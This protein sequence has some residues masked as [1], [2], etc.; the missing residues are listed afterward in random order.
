M[1]DRSNASAFA[2]VKEVTSGTFVAPSNTADLLQIADIKVQIDGITVDINE[3]TGSI[4]KVGS[5]VLGKSLTV[6]GKLY[7][8]GPGTSTPPV[9]DAWIP[10]RILQAGGL[11]ETVTSTAIPAAPEAVS[12]GTTTGFTLG[13]G[14]TGTLDLYKAMMIKLATGLGGTGNKLYTMIRSYAASKAA[15]IAETASGAITGNYQ[16]PK[17]LS[18]RTSTSSTIPTL[19]TSNWMGNYR[20][21]GVGM[22]ISAL[23]FVMPT[24]G[25]NASEPPYFEF[26]LTGDVYQ[27]ADETCPIVTA[28]LAIPPYRDGKLWVGNTQMGGTSFDVD[29]NATVAYPPNPN[30]ASGNE[31]ALLTGTQRKVS[32]NLNQYSKAT[33]DFIALADAQSYNAVMALWGSATGNMFGFLV[34]DARFNYRSPD[35]SAEY[36]TSTG[37]MFVDD[38][39][40]T[41]SLCIPFF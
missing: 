15:T 37:E 27:D 8:R 31:T 34:S 3:Y 13:A 6:S 14:A 22:A 2:V 41:V 20:V 33:K 30:N 35:N 10:G 39:N 4:H 25:R 38:A 11:A 18:Y 17:Q 21:D 32:L 9:A 12:A 1:V 24:T 29:F 23:K 5:V 16:L 26:T 36:V 28:G 7:L 40:R 19:S